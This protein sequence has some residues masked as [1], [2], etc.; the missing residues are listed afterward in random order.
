MTNDMSHY[1]VTFRHV[2]PD[3]EPV[4]FEGVHM[5]LRGP[6]AW[7]WKLFKTMECEEAATRELWPWLMAEKK[8]TLEHQ[9]QLAK[10]SG[11][12]TPDNAASAVKAI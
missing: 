6:L 5:I 11:A 9:A 10:K 2:E 4:D 7:F 12:L 3:I 8:R 1:K